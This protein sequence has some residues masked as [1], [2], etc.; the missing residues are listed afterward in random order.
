[1]NFLGVLINKFEQEDVHAQYPGAWMFDPMLVAS[2]PKNKYDWFQSKSSSYIPFVK[3]DG[4]LYILE[5]TLTGE[6]YLYSRTTS[7]VTGLLVE[8][9][10]RVPHIKDWADKHLPNGCAIVGEI[11][12]PNCTSKDITKV[13]GCLPQKA[14]KTQAKSGFVGFYIHDLIML[15]GNPLIDVAFKN[16]YEKLKSTLPADGQKIAI[17]LESVYEF[18]VDKAS[19]QYS[20]IIA[21]PIEIDNSKDIYSIASD[22][23]KDGYEGL[24]LKNPDGL[25]VPSKRPA[26]NMVKIKKQDKL[27]VICTGYYAP[28]VEYTGS[29][30]ESWK[31][32]AIELKDI[33]LI[34]NYITPVRIDKQRQLAVFV[35][36]KPTETKS[37]AVTKAY[38]MDW[39]G[40]L[41]FSAYDKDQ[42][43]VI[44]SVSSG[45]T[46]ELKEAFK[47]DQKSFI[48][49]PMAL[50]CMEID[51]TAKTV[52]HAYLE[53]FRSDIDA[54]DCTF[55]KIFD[56]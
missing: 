42:L 45:L 22:Y 27:D 3:L 51:A 19:Y 20:I 54:K 39:I 44:G 13:M 47:Q 30:I 55:S 38:A 26:W 46:E 53:H 32:W 21:T 15:N 12:L 33:A 5:K 1:M 43:K 14:L 11:S 49:S 24:V 29:E 10:D 40:A 2:I 48:G 41:E 17:G 52:R 25:Y 50:G 23:I 34:S 37:T 28:T 7:A 4:A 18:I 35:G 9:I 31:Y 56:N 8:K 36:D 6:V 16:R